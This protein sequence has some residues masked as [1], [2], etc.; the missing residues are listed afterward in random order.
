MAIV[1]PTDRPKSVCNQRSFWWRFCVVTLFFVFFC[2]C[3]GF[4]HRT[5]S[6][7]CLFLLVSV[8]RSIEVKLI[9]VFILVL[10]CYSWLLLPSLLITRDKYLDH[11]IVNYIIFG[12]EHRILYRHFY[13]KLNLS[14]FYATEASVVYILNVNRSYPKT[15]RSWFIFLFVVLSPYKIEE[16]SYDV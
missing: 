1:T 2:R 4:C 15:F 8:T 12:I 14:A 10:F 3:R 13:G 16:T 5:E 6:D 9:F 11:R 7:L